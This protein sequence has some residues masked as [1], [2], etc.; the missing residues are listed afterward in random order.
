MG[1]VQENLFVKF[2]Q[3]LAVH[4]ALSKRQELLRDKELFKFSFHDTAA[5]LQAS[6]MSS[7]IDTIII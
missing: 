2:F 7:D 4:M 6:S 1:C 5:I 3:E